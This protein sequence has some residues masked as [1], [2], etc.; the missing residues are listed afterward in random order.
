PSN[1]RTATS[2]QRRPPRIAPARCST[3]SAT[4]LRCTS[5]SRV[6]SPPLL[7]WATTQSIESSRPAIK[8]SKDIVTC[9]IKLLT[10]RCLSASRQQS[11]SW[12]I[13]FVRSTPDEQDSR[14][15]TAVSNG[16]LEHDH[17]QPPRHR[18]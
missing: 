17:E 14:S 16:R 5:M 8:P 7:H 1:L 13:P 2:Y 4:A 6:L 10:G 11:C 15:A 12:Q 3:S 9:Q 18:R